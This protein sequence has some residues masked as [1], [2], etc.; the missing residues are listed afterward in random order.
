[1]KEVFSYLDEAQ[2]LKI[3]K[4]S[5]NL[6]NNLDRCI[7]HYK[8]FSGKYLLFN[9][10]GKVEEYDHDGDLLFEG[11]YLNGKRHGKGKEYSYGDLLFEGE[12]KNGKRNGLGKQYNKNSSNL[13]FDGFYF[14]NRKLFGKQ[15]NS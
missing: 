10:N 3:A 9:Q 7:T 1:M 5:N 13:M 8:L 11:E 15:Y 12:Y 4:Y 14:D 6:Q 2:K